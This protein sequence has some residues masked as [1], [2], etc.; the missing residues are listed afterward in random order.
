V[1]DALARRAALR[2]CT[3]SLRARLCFAK[4]LAARGVSEAGRL[5]RRAGRPFHPQATLVDHSLIRRRPSTIR[6][7]GHALRRSAASFHR[8]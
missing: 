2:A 8:R 4:R 6:V 7:S 5:R 1:A 3:E